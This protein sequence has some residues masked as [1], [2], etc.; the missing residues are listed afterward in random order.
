MNVIMA[1]TLVVLH[2]G[3]HRDYSQYLLGLPWR[4]LLDACVETQLPA[5]ALPNLGRITLRNL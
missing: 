2:T 1:C 4:T 3:T 5:I